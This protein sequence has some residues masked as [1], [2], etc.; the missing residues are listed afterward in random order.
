MLHKGIFVLSKTVHQCLLFIRIQ[1]VTYPL[2]QEMQQCHDPKGQFFI[3]NLKYEQFQEIALN[4][5]VICEYEPR[6]WVAGG[7][8]TD[9]SHQVSD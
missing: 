9:E 7:V 6:L 8:V 2:S 5:I 3:F 4:D 1:I